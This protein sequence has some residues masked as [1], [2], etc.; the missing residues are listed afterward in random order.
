[1]IEK[2][3]R[4]KMKLR[5][6]L[7]L[8]GLLMLLVLRSIAQQ[9][10]W[11]ND[12]TPSQWFQQED[13]FSFTTI[14]ETQFTGSVNMAVVD[15][16]VFRETPDHLNVVYFNEN[17]SITNR[18]LVVVQI[19]EHP[20]FRAAVA[21]VTTDSTAG[22]S[23]GLWNLTDD[24]VLIV[25]RNGNVSSS[26]L[27][28]FLDDYFLELRHAPGSGLP[29]G[30]NYTYIFE[31]DDS[32]LNA[33][34]LN[35][36]S[37][38]AMIYEQDSLMIKSVSPNLLDMFQ[39]TG[40]F[41]PAIAETH[42]APTAHDEPADWKVVYNFSQNIHFTINPETDHTTAVGMFDLNGR[43]H[44]FTLLPPGENGYSIDVSQFEKGMYFLNV[45]EAEGR[46]IFSYKIWKY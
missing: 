2:M 39:P 18:Q 16:L 43:E 3:T 23:Q 8:V 20:E 37:L 13:V 4:S 41:N 45:A 10:H 27:L 5:V 24:Q 9:Y 33:M 14:S 32:T 42:E 34:N 36:A 22:Y 15:S 12:D 40:G 26:Q 30:G 31:A 21:V 29:S 11:Y 44:Y 46:L 35:T 1:M 19:S 17:S 6:T 25:F 7:L 38:A 28:Q